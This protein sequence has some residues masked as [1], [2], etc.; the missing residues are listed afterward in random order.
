MRI[1]QNSIASIWKIHSFKSYW[2]WKL[3]TKAR[4]NDEAQGEKKI[5]T[6]EFSTFCIS[7]NSV[8]TTSKRFAFSATDQLICSQ[9]RALKSFSCLI[10]ADCAL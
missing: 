7:A 4:Q 1:H 3:G 6:I 9:E 2:T 10:Q 5:S 8:K